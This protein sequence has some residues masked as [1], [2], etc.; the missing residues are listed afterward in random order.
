MV[1]LHGDL[2]G[3]TDALLEKLRCAPVQPGDT[4][5][6]LGDIGLNY[7][8][9]DYND[10]R[11]KALL[12][13]TGINFLCIHG[14]HERRPLTLDSYYTAQWCGGTVYIELP[15]PHLRFAKD[16]EI[17]DLEGYKAIALGGA[18]SVDKDYRLA[19]GWPW[20]ADE[21]PSDEIKAAAEKQLSAAG[22]KIDI[23]LS[24]T[25][26]AKYIPTEAYLFNVNQ[27]TVDKSTEEWLD[28]IESRLSY[29]AWYCGHW[30]IDKHID[31]MHFL[32]RSLE[33]L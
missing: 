4:I 25:C 31:K 28:R 2:H 23:V 21:Q 8:V 14:N 20:F 17:F 33:C 19:V 11:K 22:W 18:Y 6:L 26:P 9:G 3:E 10:Y 27:S 13:Q 15:Y 24:H 12:E 16:G 7:R 32:F 29:T 5:V 1:Y 30:H